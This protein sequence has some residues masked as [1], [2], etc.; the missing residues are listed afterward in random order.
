MSEAGLTPASVARLEPT[1]SSFAEFVA[2][3]GV[4]SLDL[5]TVEVAQGFI[6]SRLKSG[7]RPSLATQHNRR[8]ALRTL[9]AAARQLG[10]AE[11]DPTLDVMLPAAGAVRTRP[12]TDDEME[13]CRDVAQWSSAQVAAAWALA[14]ATARGAEI[15][16]V[17]ARDVDLDQGTVRL[18]GGARTEPR[19]AHLTT[20]G[21]EALRRRLDA[22][23]DASTVAFSGSGAAA[24]QASTCRAISAVLVR[25]GVGGQPG[26]RPASVAGWAGRG[27]FDRTGSIEAAARA[28]G[29]RSLDRAALLIGLD[30]SGDA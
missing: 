27:V 2:S 10:L 26:V 28:M 30:W 9:Y 29:V 19:Q 7:R 11:G 18:T 23:A 5:V 8:T 14:E 22:L 13:R 20:W 24:G 25:A 12:L 3:S 17:E 4:S 15:A 6:G 21:V 1:L 16:L